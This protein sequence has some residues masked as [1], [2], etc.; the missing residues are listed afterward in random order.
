MNFTQEDMDIIHNAF[1]CFYNECTAGY[2]GCYSWYDE[3]MREKYPDMHPFKRSDLILEQGKRA[4]EI[5]AEIEEK[6]EKKS[7]FS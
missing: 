4:L 2:L 1:V 6:Y 7:L 3:R 5:L